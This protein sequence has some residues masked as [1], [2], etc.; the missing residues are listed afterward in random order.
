MRNT[1]T[2]GSHPVYQQ[3]WPT[4]PNYTKN[5]K[6]AATNPTLKNKYRT[7]KNLLDKVIREAKAMS[8]EQELVDSDIDTR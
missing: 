6:A 3:A 2:T 1:T 4:R 7:Y 5:H 8:T